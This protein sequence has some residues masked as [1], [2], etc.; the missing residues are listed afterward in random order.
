[1]VGSDGSLVGYSG[2]FEN[3]RAL[4]DHEGYSN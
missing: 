1:V 4:L 2:G 3:K